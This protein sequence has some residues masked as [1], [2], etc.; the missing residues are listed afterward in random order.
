MVE[1]GLRALSSTVPAWRYLDH[2]LYGLQTTAQMSVIGRVPSTILQG[3]A[4]VHPLIPQDT[5]HEMMCVLCPHRKLCCTA[6]GQR[7][8]CSSV[9]P[10]DVPECNW[11][12]VEPRRG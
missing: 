4:V 3:V 12:A 2:L 1:T 9:R 7:R 8:W 5:V 6:G 11:V 10:G